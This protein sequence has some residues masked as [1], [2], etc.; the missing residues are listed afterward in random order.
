MKAIILALTVLAGSLAGES[1]GTFTNPVLPS[2]PDPWVIT[3]DGY[4]YYMNSTGKN[5]TIWK[6]RSIADLAKAEKKIVW[7]PPPSG[8]HSHDIWA[9]ELHFLQGKWYIYFAA[10][11][12]TNMTHRLWVLENPSPDP[13]QGQWTLKGKVTDPSDKWAIDGTVLENKGRMYL[14]WS[15]WEGDTNGTQSIYIAELSNP[16]TV[17]G[18]RVKLSSPEYSW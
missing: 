10:D 2:G 6:A 16:W 1:S 15:G 18:K 5:L 17:K 7:T 9:P 4:Y 8:P 12:G 13:L 11:A 14:V 3:K